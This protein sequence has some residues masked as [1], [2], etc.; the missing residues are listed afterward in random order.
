MIV[1]RF[2]NAIKTGVLPVSI[3]FTWQKI[4]GKCTSC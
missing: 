4:T 3:T 2:K 1:L